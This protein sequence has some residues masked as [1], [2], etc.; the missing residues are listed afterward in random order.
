M[1]GHSDSNYD[2]DKDK[3]ISTS[4]YFFTCGGGGVAW[5]SK[6]PDL[7][8]KLFMNMEYQTCSIVGQ[9]LQGLYHLLHELK[10]RLE[11]SY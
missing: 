5:T 9:Y 8:S 4:Y 11:G 10:F 1:V 6:N 7:I 3:R 2:D